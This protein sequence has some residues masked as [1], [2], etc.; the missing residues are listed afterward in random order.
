MKEIHLR[1][2]SRS[3]LSRHTFIVL[4]LLPVPPST[5]NHEDWATCR[6]DSSYLSLSVDCLFTITGTLYTFVKCSK[7][8][9]PY[10]WRLLLPQSTWVQRPGDFNNTARLFLHCKALQDMAGLCKSCD[11]LPG[12][13]S[14]SCRRSPILQRDH[15]AMWRRHCQGLTPCLPVCLGQTRIPICMLYGRHKALGEQNLTHF[16]TDCVIDSK[17]QF[18]LIA[19]RVG[20]HWVSAIVASMAQDP[21]GQRPSCFSGRLAHSHIFWRK[22]HNSPLSCRTL[23]A[24]KFGLSVN[25]HRPVRS[26]RKMM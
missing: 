19:E 16:M 3:H 4:P 9:G 24:S 23:P 18:V 20:T 25:Y 14:K 13:R 15:P 6:P 7:F 2:L 17:G 8:C 12:S 1:L 5:I 22:C 10:R 21:L 26:L 11:I